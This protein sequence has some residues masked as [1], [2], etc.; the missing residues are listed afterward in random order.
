MRKWLMG[1][2]AL[3][4][5]MLLIN[6]AVMTQGQGCGG[7]FTPAANCIIPGLWNWTNAAGPWAIN[8]TTVAISA[9][10]LNTT[11][12]GSRTLTNAEVLALNNTPI[13]VVAAPATGYYL[14]PLGGA[15][16][17]NYTSAYSGGSD[18]KIFYTSR[19]TGPA[20]SDTIT[21]SGFLS[22]SSDQIRNFLGVP[23]NESVPTTAAPLVIQAVANTAWGGG[24]ASNTVT[25]QIRYLLHANGL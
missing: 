21:N 5:L 20:A 25:V 3:L 6:P 13:T 1:I 15:V 10:D 24:N 22:A 8:G 23:T 9:N 12:Y 11:H 17:F 4:L 19:V 16:V 14:E 18:L 7:A 2:A